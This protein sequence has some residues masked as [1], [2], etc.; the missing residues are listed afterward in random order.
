MRGDWE[1]RVDI[2]T[3]L[4]RLASPIRYYRGPYGFSADGSPL[5]LCTTGCNM[6]V[7]MVF[8]FME[9]YAPEAFARARAVSI[10][11]GR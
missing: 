10:I 1:R 2:Q 9:R 3:E 11:I 8:G 4:K 5:G 7:K 6:G